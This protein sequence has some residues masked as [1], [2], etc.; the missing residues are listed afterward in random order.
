MKDEN[1][2]SS[3]R[4]QQHGKSNARYWSPFLLIRLVISA[5][6]A[7]PL[8]YFVTEVVA[9]FIGPLLALIVSIGLLVLMIYAILNN[10]S[11]LLA[12][13]SV[14]NCPQC[15]REIAATCTICPKCN[16]RF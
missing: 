4:N 5:L 3:P 12:E 6:I 14:Y 9:V 16:H 8:L 2:Y 7:I 11:K 13:S 15:N 10:H 1:P